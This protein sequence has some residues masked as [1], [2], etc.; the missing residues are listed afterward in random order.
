MGKVHSNI[1]TLKRRFSQS[2]NTKDITDADY[3]H[4]KTVCKD[5]EIKDLRE[6]HDL[7]AKSNTLFLAD[8]FDNFRNTCLKIYK[9]Y[10]AKVPSATGLAWHAAF[11]KD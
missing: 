1:V 3:A 2:L 7:Y 10:L 6:Y 11:K 9:L 4:A 8:L 5:F